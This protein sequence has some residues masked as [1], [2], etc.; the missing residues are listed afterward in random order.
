MNVTG[1][2]EQVLD[3]FTGVLTMTLHKTQYVQYNHKSI[4][5]RHD[6]EYVTLKIKE[7]GVE[8]TLK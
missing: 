3:T 4:L 8:V 5:Q 7:I 2:H 6:M 1:R